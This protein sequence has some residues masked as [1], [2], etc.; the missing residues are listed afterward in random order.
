LDNANGL[1][2]GFV[3]ST[4]GLVLPKPFAEEKDID[5]LRLDFDTEEEEEEE[6]EEDE[7]E[8]IA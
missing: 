8:F 5:L 2:N 4:L 3:S 7:E 1:S 6:E